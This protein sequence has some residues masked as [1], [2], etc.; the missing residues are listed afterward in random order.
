MTVLD[1]VPV[2]AITERAA[3]V[4]PGKVALAWLTAAAT[5]LAGLLYLVGWV[6]AKA[7]RGLWLA[8]AFTWAAVA[9][10]WTDAWP[11]PDRGDG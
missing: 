2:A 3:R 8:L 7:L 4:H 6:P 5:A 1:H 10:G 11:R 9:E